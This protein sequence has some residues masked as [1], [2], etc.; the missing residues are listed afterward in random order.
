MS[1]QA[2]TILMLYLL[3]GDALAHAAKM[4]LECRDRGLFP[5]QEAQGVVQSVCVPT[6]I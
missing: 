4:L 3:K 5:V 1:T 6:V 2:H